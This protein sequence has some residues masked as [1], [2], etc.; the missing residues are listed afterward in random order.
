MFVSRFFYPSLRKDQIR[1]ACIIFYYYFVRGLV[2][3]SAALVKIHARGCVGCFKY[4]EITITAV[5]VVNNSY[6]NFVLSHKLLGKQQNTGGTMSVCMY[7]IGHRW[8]CWFCGV[9]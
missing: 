2:G 1:T 8:F 6:N 7:L 5:T 3:I 4:N 9:F